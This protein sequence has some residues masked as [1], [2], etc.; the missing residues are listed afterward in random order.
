MTLALGLRAAIAA[1]LLGL[2][3][4]S[5]AQSAP[6]APPKQKT[7]TPSVGQAGKDVI[8]VPSPDQVVDRMLRMAQTTSRDTVVDLGSGDGKIVIAAAQRFG[9]RAIGVE[10]NPD[11]VALSRANLRKAGVADRVEVVQGDF[12]AVDFSRATVLTLYLLPDLN[13]KLRPKI[14][15]LAPGTR[16][17]SH[18]FDMQDW[19][20]DELSLLDGKRAYFWIVPARVDGRWTLELMGDSPA[21]IDIGFEQ[22]FQKLRGYASLG[23]VLAGLRDARLRGTQIR[24]AYVDNEGL[25]R[26]FTGRVN[27]ARMEGEYRSGQGVKHRW[28]AV[29]R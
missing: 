20:P 27:G 2:S 3:A 8:W 6:S 12:F 23:V 19:E 17:V 29:K 22:D 11:M 4:Q 28:R 7:Y 25:E 15:S 26:A 16:V 13:I 21:R 10:F 9:A 1:L 18:S 14:L 24:F 5:L